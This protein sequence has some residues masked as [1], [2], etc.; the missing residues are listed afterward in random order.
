[1][2]SWTVCARRGPRSCQKRV[3]R[4][5]RAASLDWSAVVEGCGRGAFSS[6][7]QHAHAQFNQLLDSVE[8]NGYTEYG[9]SRRTW[10]GGNH[11]AYFEPH[12]TVA[13]KVDWRRG[14]RLAGGAIC[15]VPG[16]VRERR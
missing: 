2:P 4:A 1:M 16:K 12:V 9:S 7:G 5:F 3:D 15:G 8:L 11:P 14:R 13:C 10:A 6:Q